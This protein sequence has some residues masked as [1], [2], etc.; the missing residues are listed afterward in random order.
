MATAPVTILIARHAGLIEIE[1]APRPMAAFDAITV[2]QGA[3]VRSAAGQ[4]LLSEIGPTV[5]TVIAT[6][7]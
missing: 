1:G 2:P 7:N 5:S 3:L 4:L 6:S